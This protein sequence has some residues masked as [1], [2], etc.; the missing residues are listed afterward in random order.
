MR[1]QRQTQDNRKATDST[2]AQ[3][4]L[5]TAAHAHAHA[6]LPAARA[7][8]LGSQACR[9]STRLGRVTVSSAIST[10]LSG[11]RLGVPFP[12]LEDS[13]G[14]TLPFTSPSEPA[15]ARLSVRVTADL[16]GVANVVQRG[17][18]HPPRSDYCLHLVHP[19]TTLNIGPAMHNPCAGPVP[20]SPR[21]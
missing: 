9:S 4:L 19:S 10:T 7:S 20:P 2:A 5:V 17:P 21:V 8:A 15:S 16:Q 11:R 12:T 6:H 14:S 18:V 1:K 3:E 13:T